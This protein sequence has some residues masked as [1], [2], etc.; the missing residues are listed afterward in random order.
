M[1]EKKIFHEVKLPSDTNKVTVQNLWG[2]CDA[3]SRTGRVFT[4][5][6]LIKQNCP[7]NNSDPVGRNL[8][9]LKYLGFLKEKRERAPNKKEKIQ[10]YYWADNQDVKDF[11]YLLQSK[12]KEESRVKWKSIIAS[13]NLSKAVTQGV[14][15]ERNTATTIELEDFLRR[16][17]GEKS[18]APYYQN[19]AKF[20]SELLDDAGI[21]NY[22]RSQNMLNLQVESERKEIKEAEVIQEELEEK[23][24]GS[25]NSEEYIVSIKGKDLKLDIIIKE[26]ED[27]E[28]LES[29]IN[30]LKRK[31]QKQE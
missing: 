9:Y 13:S 18:N 17:T 31:I 7:H 10:R 11:Y 1:K 26:E 16:S 21:V 14:F 19:S 22:D 23:V 27:I 6:Q 24:L 12:R 29:F 4:M 25:N 30:V 3:I 28:D 2:Y 8:S 15:K 5:D 20:V